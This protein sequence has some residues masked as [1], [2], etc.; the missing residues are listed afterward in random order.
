MAVDKQ[1][2]GKATHDSLGVCGLDIATIQ[3]LGSNL[4]IH[5]FLQCIIPIQQALLHVGSYK[6][7]P[8]SRAMYTTVQQLHS[9]NTTYETHTHTHAHAPRLVLLGHKSGESSIVLNPLQLESNEDD[10]ETHTVCITAENANRS[11]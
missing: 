10:Y 8:R 1:R 7:W 4:P 6:P 11:K 5:I 9:A 3:L 2:S